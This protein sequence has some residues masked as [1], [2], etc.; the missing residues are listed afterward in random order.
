MVPFLPTVCDSSGVATVDTGSPTASDFWIGPQRYGAALVYVSTDAVADTDTRMNGLRYTSDGALRV[1]NAT[2]GMPAGAVFLGGIGVSSDGQLCVTTAAVGASTQM[3]GG[4]AVSSEGALH[5]DGL[6]S[7]LDLSPAAWFKFNTGITES[8]GFVSVWGDQSTDVVALNF[9]GTV[10]NSASTPDSAAVSVT[11]VDIAL[12]IANYWTDSATYGY[13]AGKMLAANYTFRIICNA[14]SGNI[15]FRGSKDGTTE[16]INTTSSVSIS[17]VVSNGD[18][19]WLRVTYDESTGD[20]K[21][22]TAPDS[23]SV[24]ASWTQLGTTRP[25]AGGALYNGTASL[26]ICDDGITGGGRWQ[27]CKRAILYST[28]G[29]TTVFDADFTAQTEG[30]TSFTESSSNAATVT[31]NTS[32]TPY[33]RLSKGNPLLQATGTNQPAVAS[34]IVTGD[35]ADNFMKAA[36]F[37]LPQPY[38][39]AMVCKQPTWTNTDQFFNGATAGAVYVRQDTTTPQIEAY[40]GT[41]SSNDANMTLDTW[42]VLRMIF[43]GANSSLQVD[44]NAAVTG[45][46]GAAALNGFCLFANATPSLYA[47]LGAKEAVLIPEAVSGADMTS[48]YN[49]LAA[50]R[51]A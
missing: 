40:A 30:A 49:Y 41:A 23:D 36:S 47:N 31:I 14:T 15:N 13:L 33:A 5:V 27:K 22:Y 34:G 18:Y 45:N 35:G 42:C 26:Y 3:I 21:Y 25:S 7:P 10:G 16:A 38:T 29:G 39:I 1:Y 24:P 12:R 32:G 28:V 19:I 2:G 20:V 48:L 46:F 44:A 9:P 51:D 37:Y 8:G 17:S 50:V 4:N 6:F 43:D 11:S